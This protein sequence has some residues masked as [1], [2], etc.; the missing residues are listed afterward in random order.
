ME[1]VSGAG[2]WRVMATEVKYERIERFGRF[3]SFRSCDHSSRVTMILCAVETH[4]CIIGT[5]SDDYVKF[6]WT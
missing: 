3:W 2:Q 6:N 1:L 5:T 4:T